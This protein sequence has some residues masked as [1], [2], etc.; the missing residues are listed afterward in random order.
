V[1]DETGRVVGELWFYLA[2]GFDSGAVAELG[3]AELDA[4]G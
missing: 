4:F 2:E 3:V 1:R